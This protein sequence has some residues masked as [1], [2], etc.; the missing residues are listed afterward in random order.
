MIRVAVVLS[1]CGHLDGA[2]IRE[3]VLS[4]L[5]LDEHGAKASVFAPDMNQM[6]VVNHRTGDVVPGESRNVLTEAARIAR[7]EIAPLEKLDAAEFDALILPGGF[8][9]AK[10]LSDFAING[11]EGCILPALQKTIA[12]FLEA[13]KPVGAIC[14]APALLALAAKDLGLT[15]TIG[16]DA[17]VAD[18]IESLGH[19]HRNS[20]VERAVVDKEHH[21][22]T[23]PAYM[24]DAPIAAVAKGIRHMVEEV[25]ALSTARK[26]AA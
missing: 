2:E 22:V 3:A 11:A 4:L 12:A 25:L 1:G 8:G 5:Y 6:H 10:N 15:L 14:I 7:G 21:V 18:T 24:Y 13:R 20:P 26:K 23:C 16:Q 9:A 19:R 17:G